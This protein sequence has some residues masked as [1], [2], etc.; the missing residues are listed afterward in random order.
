MV[1]IGVLV[2]IISSVS[3]SAETLTDES[4][5]VYHW[6]MTGSTWSWQPST[7]P[8]SYIDITE[9]TYTTSEDKFTL[10]MKVSGEIQSSGNVEYMAWV[11]TSDATYQMYVMGGQSFGM[12]MNTEDDGFQV[13]WNPNITISGNTVTCTFDLVGTDVIGSEFYGWAWEYEELGAEN[14]ELWQDWIPN[15]SSPFWDEDGDG[16]GDE[17]GNGDGDVNG[18]GGG[19]DTNGGG[20][21]G[22]EAV[23]LISALAV[24]IIILRRRK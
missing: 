18:D 23:A 4:G 5:D 12:A 21:P 20:T 16:N 24:V 15:T 3:V 17:D 7:D 2:L 19:S 10:S 8:K 6:K 13:D 14:Q 9:L 1:L 22:F 11:N